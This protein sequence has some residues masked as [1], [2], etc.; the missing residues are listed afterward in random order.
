MNVRR[1][2]TPKKLRRLTIAWIR[3][4]CSSWESASTSVV[5]RVITLPAI[6]WS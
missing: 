4:V 3:P 5:M 1:M 2:S 6:S